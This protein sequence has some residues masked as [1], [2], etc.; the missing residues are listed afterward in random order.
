MPLAAQLVGVSTGAK[1]RGFSQS[2]TITTAIGTRHHQPSHTRL[3]IARIISGIAANRVQTLHGF[4]WRFHASSVMPNA[5]A[6]FDVRLMEVI[7]RAGVGDAA[8]D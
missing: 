7:V 3:Q 6:I 8:G 1:T 4:A 5:P 2:H